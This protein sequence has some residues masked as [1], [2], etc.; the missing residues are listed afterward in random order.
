MGRG[1]MTHPRAEATGYRTI[2]NMHT[3][4]DHCDIEVDA[5]ECP[6]CGAGMYDQYGDVA[7]DEYEYLIDWI[8][9]EFM[10]AFPSMDK[11]D[12]W[13]H[14]CGAMNEL[15]CVVE[16][17]LCAIYV[18]DYC[19]MVSIS[20]VP[21]GESDYDNDTTGLATAWCNKNAQRVLDKLD[22]YTRVSTMSNGESVYERRVS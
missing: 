6:E 13:A 18:A 19:N 11:C 21:T 10:T 14:G 3:Y 12:Y 1:V 7:R 20:V 16:N 17:K 2:S 5:D 22:E 4:C 9:E 15:R 8:R